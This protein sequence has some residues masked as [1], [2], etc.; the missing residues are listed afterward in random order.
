MLK[1]ASKKYKIIAT[2]ILSTSLTA[3]GMFFDKDNT[4]TP[5]PLTSFT[6]ETSPRLLWSAKVG[7]GAIGNDYLKMS[8]AASETAIYTASTKGL[9]TALNKATGHRNWRV[10]TRLP[11]T[12]GPSVND[13]IVVI[14][15][16]KGSL[17]AFTETDGRE[18][19]RAAVHGEVMATPAIGNGV[20]VVKTVDGHTHAFSSRAGEEIWSYQQVEPNLILRGASKPLIHDQA[21][22]IGYANGNLAKF[23]VNDGQLLWQQTVATPEGAFA[24]Q[25]M[26]DIDA[27]PIVFDHRIYVAT[28]QGRISSLDFTSGRT[29]WTHDISSYTG[30][31]ADESSVYVSDASGM[32]F[33]FNADD[34]FINWRQ[35]KLK[36]RV[37]SA[38]ASQS[39]YVVIGDSEGYLH[40]LNKSDGRFAARASLGSAIYATP[41]VKNNV[42]YAL[43]N[44]GYLAAY[45]L[46]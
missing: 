29:L 1:I 2:F 20:V 44:S 6:A 39:H 5:T 25:R 26:I 46:R 21:A 40:W 34:G 8:P 14:C 19:W 45:T 7:A 23:N 36:Y 17:L 11:L 41:I 27:D 18:I 32:V 15:S 33:K 3:C 35:N 4:P 13:G 9:V 22:I 43:T 28:Y 42:L 12:A 31:V 30:M 38:P 16:Q 37:I 10:D 24:I